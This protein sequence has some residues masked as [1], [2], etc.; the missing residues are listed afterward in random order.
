MVA[1]GARAHGRA[2][3]RPP[4]SRSIART[5]AEPLIGLL[6]AGHGCSPSAGGPELA[7]VSRKPG[8]GG[9]RACKRAL[10]TAFHGRDSPARGCGMAEPSGKG[11]GKSALGGESGGSA[12]LGATGERPSGRAT[13]RGL[14]TTSPDESGKQAWRAEGASFP[15]LPFASCFAYLP[16]GHGA[17]CEQG[18]LLCAQL[19][20]ADRAWLPRLA[21]QSLD[22]D[23]GSRALCR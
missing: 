6:L 15:A 5:L 17:V 2:C 14:A 13:R 4:S 10:A 18:R 16:A 3:R 19:K 7:E 9:A 22:G 23:D 20:A 12:M 1:I 8:A 11:G 21:A